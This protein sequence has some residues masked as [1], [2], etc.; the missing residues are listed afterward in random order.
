MIALDV[1]TGALRARD[2]IAATWLKEDISAGKSYLAEAR[3]TTSIRASAC[4]Q[5]ATLEPIAN[6]RRLA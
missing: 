6:G 5:L 4:G 3:K 2:A 1:T